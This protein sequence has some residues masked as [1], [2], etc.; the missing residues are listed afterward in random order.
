MEKFI[1]VKD[2]SKMVSRFNLKVRSIQFKIKPIPDNEKDNAIEWIKDA[3]SQVISKVTDDLQPED[4]VGFSLCS[5]SF[6]RG[7]CWVKFQDADNITF[8]D[9]WE[10]LE[11]LFQ[12]NSTGLN[13]DTFCLEATK[14]TLP[15][16]SGR[17]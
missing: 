13:T 11:M 17:K 10:K 14:V 9:I 12:P 6:S 3:L 5:D 1:V 8:N 7:S 15:K 2:A 16:G 4:K